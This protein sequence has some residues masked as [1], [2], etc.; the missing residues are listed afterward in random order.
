MCQILV[1]SLVLSLRLN[2][3]LQ[4]DY[5]EGGLMLLIWSRYGTKICQ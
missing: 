2:S 4:S 1:V 3:L 5:A